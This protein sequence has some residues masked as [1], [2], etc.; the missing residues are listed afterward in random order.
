VVRLDADGVA[1]RLEAAIEQSWAR[2]GD[3][4]PA[5]LG[6][7]ARQIELGHAAYRRLATLVRPGPL[8]AR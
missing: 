7:A 3:L 2:A 5:L 8:A 4:R 6:A 1:G